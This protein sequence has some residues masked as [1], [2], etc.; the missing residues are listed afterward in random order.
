ME[1]T[2]KDTHEMRRSRSGQLS[3]LQLARL[4]EIRRYHGVSADQIAGR[5]MAAVANVG[6]AEYA[7]F[8]DGLRTLEAQLIHKAIR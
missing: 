2:Q 8:M 6:C 3:P 5:L 1:R 4:E 7:R